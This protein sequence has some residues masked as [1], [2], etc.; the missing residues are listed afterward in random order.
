MSIS[1]SPSL[2]EPQICIVQECSVTPWRIH[3]N[4]WQNQHNIVKQNKAKIKI[5]KKGKKEIKKKEI[6]K[7]IL[8]LQ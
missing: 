8:H 3:V 2:T 1:H 7:Q 5:K 4:V 6:T